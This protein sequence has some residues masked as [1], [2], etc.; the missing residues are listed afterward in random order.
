LNISKNF[1][2]LRDKHYAH[3]NKNK[4]ELEHNVTL[5]KCW[6]TLLIVQEIFIELNI[7]LLNKQYIFSILA[8]EP[9]EIV[10]LLKI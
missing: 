10:S 4:F 8:E 9:Y 1:K 7:C 2:Y 5:K 6:E 3:N